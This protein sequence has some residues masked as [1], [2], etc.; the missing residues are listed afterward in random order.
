MSLEREVKKVK[1]VL[2]DS[3][4]LDPL[5]EMVSQVLQGCRAHQVLPAK[6][7]ELINAS[8]ENL[9]HQVVLDFQ[10]EMDFQE[11]WERKVTKGNPVPYVIK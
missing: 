9:V 3:L 1:R 11:R 4:Y 8:R 2:R 5:E 6:Q 10:E 7:M